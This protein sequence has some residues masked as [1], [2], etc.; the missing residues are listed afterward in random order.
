MNLFVDILYLEALAAYEAKSK[1]PSPVHESN[2]ND[3]NLEGFFDD[4]D[5]E[6]FDPENSHTDKKRKLG[7]EVC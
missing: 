5:W 3:L 4:D 2:V 7:V 6:E 1:T